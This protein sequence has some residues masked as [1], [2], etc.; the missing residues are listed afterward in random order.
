M[1]PLAENPFRA[2]KLYGWEVHLTTPHEIA[3]CGNPVVW[4]EKRIVTCDGIRMLTPREEP[5]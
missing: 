3:V 5:E 2:G 4:P 1:I